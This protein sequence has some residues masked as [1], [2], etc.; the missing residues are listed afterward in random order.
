MT[1]V[2]QFGSAFQASFQQP[3]WF[4]A[5]DPAMSEEIAASNVSLERSYAKMNCEESD[6]HHIGSDGSLS[7][8]DGENII[9]QSYN[10]SAENPCYGISTTT[11]T[12]TN[13][14]L[15]EQNYAAAS[16][17]VSASQDSS[18]LRPLQPPINSKVRLKSAKIP[19]KQGHSGNAI[20]WK[21]TTWLRKKCTIHKCHEA[22]CAKAYKKSSHLK[23]HLRTHTG[24]KPY[25][26]SWEDC[27]WKFARSDELTRHFR[28]HTG[29]KPFQCRLCGRA[30]SRSDHLS[31]HAKRHL[32]E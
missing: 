18:S 20:I 15:G 12:D 1:D 26:C 16:D 31:L 24:E 8:V 30:F 7:Y 28:K 19:L 32:S 4:E 29:D 5:N 3:Q 17:P 2:G 25:K 10:E 22:G 6:Y 27:T 14:Y 23:A 21:Q 11:V 9:G 13:M